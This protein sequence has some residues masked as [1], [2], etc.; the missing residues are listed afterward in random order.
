MAKKKRKS[1][2]KPKINVLEILIGGLIDLIVGTLLI[3]I[4]Y[5]FEK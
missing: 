4:G 3:V 5:F 1:Q 2:P